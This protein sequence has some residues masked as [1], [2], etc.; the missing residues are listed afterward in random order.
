MALQPRLQLSS[1]PVGHPHKET[2]KESATPPH[3]HVRHGHPPAV[4]SKTLST[5]VPR[6]PESRAR[7]CRIGASLFG[8]RM[9]EGPKERTAKLFHG[10]KK[11]IAANWD[12]PTRSYWPAAM[13]SMAPTMSTVHHLVWSDVPG[14]MRPPN[15]RLVDHHNCFKHHQQD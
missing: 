9:I 11:K 8:T 1:F 15:R 2:G 6:A 13:C 3:M 10:W 14:R 5:C 7:S 12:V 4:N